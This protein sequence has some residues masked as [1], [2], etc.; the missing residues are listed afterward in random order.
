MTASA[1]AVVPI[2]AFTGAKKR[3]SGVLDDK[4][5]EAL[6]RAMARDVL[7]VLIALK[8]ARKLDGILVVTGSVEVREFAQGFGV[9]CWDDPKQGDLTGTLEA[10]AEHLVLSRRANSMMILPSDVP[11]VRA[12]FLSQALDDHRSLTLASDDLGE[13]TNLLIASPPNL[14]RLCYD[15]HGFATHLARGR[16]LEVSPEVVADPTIALDVDM[17][18]DLRRLREFAAHPRF[19]QAESVKISCTIQFA[20]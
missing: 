12:E 10:T 20:N 15:G 5:R 3:L 4:G 16:A 13:G 9:D 2:K 6:A 17:P 7:K 14:I 11:L 1:W 8:R 18:E 19:G